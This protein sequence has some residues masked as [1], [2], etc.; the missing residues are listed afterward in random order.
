MKKR[1]F[2]APLGLSIAALIGLT[3]QVTKSATLPNRVPD[4]DARPNGALP[5]LHASDNRYLMTLQRSVQGDSLLIAHGSHS[6][7]SS[8]SSHASSSVPSS[9]S[10][11]GLVPTSASTIL[12]VPVGYPQIMM[13]APTGWSTAGVL[14]VK[15]DGNA[16][17]GHWASLDGEQLVV[18]AMPYAG[19]AQSFISKVLTRL[20]GDHTGRLSY[21][22]QQVCP[23]LPATFNTMRTVSLEGA[24][25]FYAATAQRGYIV[26]AVYHGKPSQAGFSNE[27][28]ASLNSLCVI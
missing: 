25:V 17:L 12:T 23:T 16:T 10:S 11:D 3:P 1:V 14:D 20:V 27:A 13:T 15:D 24:P 19:S 2:L 28:L 4:D 22:T 21:G 18:H 8:H 26:W 5:D 6:S 9:G 7:H